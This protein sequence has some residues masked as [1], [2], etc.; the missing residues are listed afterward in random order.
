MSPAVIIIGAAVLAGLI[1]FP[2]KTAPEAAAEKAI[3]ASPEVGALLTAAAAQSEVHE[4]L[5]ETAKQALLSGDVAG[6]FIG[7]L[8]A[9]FTRGA[10]A[11]NRA[12]WIDLVVATWAQLPDGWFLERDPVTAWVELTEYVQRPV[13]L[14]RMTEAEWWPRFVAAETYAV[15]EYNRMRDV[16]DA[17]LALLYGQE[18]R[19]I[20]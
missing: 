13:A 8:G 19:R 9:L 15:P 10:R 1:L 2:P 6:A 18:R 12:A 20:A 4:E 7:T 3:E 14:T 17:R 11:E 16:W 5:R